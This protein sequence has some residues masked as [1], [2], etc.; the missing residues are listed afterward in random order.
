MRDQ[1]KV[2]ELTT[3]P[4]WNLLIIHLLRHTQHKKR[5]ISKGFVMKYC[6]GYGTEWVYTCQMMADDLC[7][8]QEG[9]G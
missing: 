3:K 2:Q 4:L 8:Y 1:I 9:L 7:R 5:L 6:C